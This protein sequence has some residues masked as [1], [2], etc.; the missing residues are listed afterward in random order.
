METVPRGEER[1]REISS[2]SKIKQTFSFLFFQ[3]VPLTLASS[4]Y[5]LAFLVT[6]AFSLYFWLFENAD[7]KW[8]ADYLMPTKRTE[9]Q[10]CRKIGRKKWKSSNMRKIA[11]KQPFTATA[12]FSSSTSRDHIQMI[13]IY[14]YAFDVYVSKQHFSPMDGWNR[15]FSARISSKIK[16]EFF[17]SARNHSY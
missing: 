6:S 16:K 2:V 1:E 13:M 11:K 17:V 14:V 7:F 12:H 8:N 3:L 10:S 4:L 5:V 9:R 15:I